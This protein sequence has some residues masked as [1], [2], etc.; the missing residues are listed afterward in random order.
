MS[1]ARWFLQ[2][3]KPFWKASLVSV[4]MGVGT[5]A[6]GIGLLGTSAFL[7]SSA[8]LHPS[9]AEL[10]VAIVGVRF[11]GIARG[12]FRYGERLVSH[13]V[14]L[15]LLANLRTWLFMKLAVI[16]PKGV[17]YQSSADV[18]QTLIS[19]VDQLE[20]I[21]VRIITP[22]LTGVIVAVG[23]PSL[24]GLWS[25]KAA[26]ILFLGICVSAFGV[27]I[28]TYGLC[29]NAGAE[30]VHWQ[31]ISRAD[32]TS[33]ITGMG[34]VLIYDQL[35]SLFQKTIKSGELL[36]KA[37]VAL[38]NRSALGEAIS[39]WTTQMT[40]VT[41]LLVTIPLVAKGELTGTSL[42]VIALIFL[43]SFE[44]ANAI[45]MGASQL[46]TS[47]AA[48]TRIQ[49]LV[50]MS[51]NE[52]NLTS[53]VPLPSTLDLSL[54]HVDFRY[55]ADAP[56]ALL[57]INLDIPYGKRIAILGVNGS[58][59]TTLFNLLL[60]FWEPSGGQ[61]T[62]DGIDFRQISGDDLRRM[63]AWSP[64][65]PFIFSASLRVNLQLAAPDAPDEVL[66]HAL[67]SVYLSDWAM[68]LPDGLDTWMGEQGVAVSA[69]ERQRIS[70]ARVILQNAP[71]CLFD[72]PTTN[73]DQIT[74]QAIL[75]MLDTFTYGKTVLM[76]T[77][78][79]SALQMV[80]EVVILHKGAI[81]ESGE[82][83][84]LK[85]MSAS[86]LNRIVVLEGGYLPG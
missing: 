79:L 51:E 19:D 58:G 28:L 30:V 8:A 34:E 53:K 24:V 57:D 43:A 15:R 12:L 68:A 86:V 71:I 41:G 62:I 17:T 6:A 80:E 69:G 45:Q 31:H 1:I 63:I 16:A 55:H 10:Q 42:A 78:H 7:I 9:I 22:I 3:L 49:T 81:I 4:L 33:I 54:K 61:M 37:K 59:K 25:W 67:E 27:P 21:Y 77:H 40:L 47:L 56:P 44:V 84:V 38:A 70:L 35:S 73:L 5:I 23:A 14:N 18:S 46:Q 2:F 13:E 76:A 75:Q 64:Q 72:E 29:R 66:W 32:W 36:I 83:Q 20:N 26:W 50:S 85:G 74:E 82:P 60:G 11:F 65:H 39:L 48:A 52:I